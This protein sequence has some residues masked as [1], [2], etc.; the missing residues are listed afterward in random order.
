MNPDLLASLLSHKEATPEM[1]EHVFL[2]GK[3]E[4]HKHIAA[5][6]RAFTKQLFD[7]YKDDPEKFELMTQSR[8]FDNWLKQ[9]GNMDKVLAGTNTYA[10]FNATRHPEFKNWVSRV[11]IDKAFEHPSKDVVLAASRALNNS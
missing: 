10:H 8:H 7:K 3:E 2:H 6:S 5:A 11:G 9:P 1:A 4:N